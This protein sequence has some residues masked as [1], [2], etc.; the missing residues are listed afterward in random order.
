MR[1]V[2]TGAL[3]VSICVLGLISWSLASGN[4]T[5]PSKLGHPAIT[6]ATTS[7]TTTSTTTTVPA[8]PSAPQSSANGAADA[9]VGFW[10][11]GNRPGALTVATSSAVAA[12]FA[13]PYPNGDAIN[14]GCATA[15]PPATCTIGPPGGADPNLPIYSFTLL[16]AP[17]G[18]W[19]VNAVQVEG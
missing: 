19:Y 12:L 9:L 6:P 14:R 5:T 1:L 16:N 11:D 10:A 18:G 2:L 17:N 13:V 7:T 8:I 3:V 4:P 15:F